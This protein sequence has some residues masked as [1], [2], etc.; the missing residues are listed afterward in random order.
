MHQNQWL[1]AAAE[2][3]ESDFPQGK[4]HTDQFRAA[5]ALTM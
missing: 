1:A 5:G 2:L 4:E 3:R